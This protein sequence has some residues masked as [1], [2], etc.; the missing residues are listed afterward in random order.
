METREMKRR[1]ALVALVLS[2][3]VMAA[4]GYLAG[5]PKDPAVRVAQ[6]DAGSGRYFSALNELL[7]IPDSSHS[8]LSVATDYRWQLADDYLS[9]GMGAKAESLYR[10][11]AVVTT[12]HVQLAKAR[13]R[14]ADFEYQH[15]YQTEARNLLTSM[16]DKLPQSL[17]P[18]WQSQLVRGLLAQNRYPEAIDVLSKYG[19]TG[20]LSEY[21]RYNLGVSLINAGRLPEGRDMLDRVGR[22][23]VD[24]SDDLAL[25]DKA[26][27]T[28]GWHYL[29]NQMGNSAKPIFGRVRSKGPYSNRAL[30]GLGWTEMLPASQLKGLPADKTA[31][32]ASPTPFSTFSSLGQLLRPGFLEDTIFAKAF[33]DNKK[34][35]GNLSPQDE[36]ALKRALV[37]WVELIN[38]NPQDPAV[39]EGWLAI[40]YSLDRLGAHEQALRYYEFAVAKLEAARQRAQQAKASIT[41]GRMVDT[42]VRREVDAESGWEWEL[43]D[44]PDAPETY[45]LQ[46]L[47]A[48]HR[49][50]EA[51]KNYRDVRLL[52]RNLDS[53]KQKLDVLESS[54][55]GQGRASVAAEI[56]F[57]QAKAG[58]IPPWPTPVINLRLET[59]LA[60]PGR[61]DD[62]IAADKPSTMPLKLGAPKRFD[63]Q[64]EKLQA[65]RARLDALRPL[66]DSAYAE[67]GRLLQDMA[68]T[69]LEGQKKQIEKYLVEARFAL[70]RLYDKQLKGEL[71]GQ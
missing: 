64:W 58:F 18:E 19:S 34:R 12:D 59:N 56:L 1:L 10:E 69:E 42:I 67:Q 37:A 20:K 15:G 54:Y 30:L 61:Y 44:L 55:T 31:D 62:A 51:L 3:A 48:D 21:A 5:A 70:A 52:G 25:R 22:M 33:G 43:K 38:R 71:N 16:R 17:L 40:P 9:F 32:N 60:P 35:L 13:L 68:A 47:L 46:S 7:T 39:H 36:D 29:S 26:N 24:T 57:K 23:S 27:L 8:S 63:S 50:Q 66:V 28:L 11:L 49:F 4:D 6:F 65:M 2:P 53:W 41:Q 14:L 45:Y